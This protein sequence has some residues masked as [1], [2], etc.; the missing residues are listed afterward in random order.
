MWQNFF[1][2]ARLILNEWFGGCQDTLRPEISAFFVDL[3]ICR[4]NSLLILNWT[5]F[6]HKRS[7]NVVV[8]KVSCKLNWEKQEYTPITSRPSCDA[9]NGGWCG[10]YIS[11]WYKWLNKFSL[12]LLHKLRQQNGRQGHRRTNRRGRWKV[13]GSHRWQP[14]C[15]PTHRTPTLVAWWKWLSCIHFDA[16]SSKV[17]GIMKVTIWVSSGRSPFGPWLSE[18]AQ[19]ITWRGS[20]ASLV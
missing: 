13:Q 18:S 12:W 6:K 19:S 14:P 17:L 16:Y 20:S 2:L 8:S 11:N 7:N 10:I 4:L 15:L 3:Y 1:C 5:Y 9:K